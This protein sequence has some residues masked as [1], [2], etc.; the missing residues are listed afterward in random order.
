MSLRNK[1]KTLNFRINISIVSVTEGQ[2]ISHFSNLFSSCNVKWV[3]SIVMVNGASLPP[4]PGTVT[5]EPGVIGY[6]TSMVYL[7]WTVMDATVKDK[8]ENYTYWDSQLVLVQK[9]GKC[10]KL[11]LDVAITSRSIAQKQAWIMHSHVLPTYTRTLLYTRA[12][13]HTCSEHVEEMLDYNVWNVSDQSA[14]KLISFSHYKS[15]PQ[16]HSHVSVYYSENRKLKS[17]AWSQSELWITIY[18]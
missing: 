17:S 15:L 16:A 5:G 12:C 11:C 6:L 18:D 4:I 3:L 14:E 1:K 2:R 10:H 7:R 8:A 9:V 13:T